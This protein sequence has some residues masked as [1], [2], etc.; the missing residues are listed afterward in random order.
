MASYNSFYGRRIW[1]GIIG[2]VK[3]AEGGLKVGGFSHI[4]VKWVGNIPQ[5]WRLG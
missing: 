3:A 2:P 4:F 5:F 1:I